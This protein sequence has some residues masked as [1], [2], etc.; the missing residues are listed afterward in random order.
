MV[1]MNGGKGYYCYLYDGWCCA[2]L[3][4]SGLP[5]APLDIEYDSNSIE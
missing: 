1:E 5:S 2:M 4:L 3:M